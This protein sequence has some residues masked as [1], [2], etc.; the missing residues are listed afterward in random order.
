MNLV[1]SLVLGVVVDVCTRSFPLLSDQGEE[2]LVE[3]DTLE[4]FLNVLA[5][6][7][8]ELEPAQI[9]FADIAVAE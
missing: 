3:C 1:A 8:R 5:L 2:R 4:Q 6:V 7:R 9:A